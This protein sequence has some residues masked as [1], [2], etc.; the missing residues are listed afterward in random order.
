MWSDVAKVGESVNTVLAKPE[1]AGKVLKLPAGIFEV[2]N[3]RDQNAG[4]RVP[5]TVKGI[6]GAGRD[7]II[8]M[9]ANTSSFGKTVPTQSAGSTN[10]LYLLRMNDGQGQTLSDFWLQGTEQ[11]HLYNGIMVGNSSPGTTVENL[12][13]TGIPGDAGTPPGETFG[14]NWWRGSDS[15]TRDV[16]IDGYRWTGDSFSSRV[17]GPIVGA[18]PIGYNNHDEARL[19]NVLTHDSEVGMPTFWYSDN[20]QTWNLQ[21][22]RNVTGINHEESFNIVHH[23]PVIHG[24]YS[25]RHINFMSNKSDGKLTIIGATTDE[26][27]SGSRSGPIGKGKRML[28]LTPY[29]YRSFNDN[30][31]KSPPR[32][33]LDDGVTA[34]PYTWAH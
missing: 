2:S 13:I 21:S 19:I 26:W 20:A 34:V 7:T 29:S 27:I 15:V 6:V 11:G 23:Q 24:S 1:L 4:I 16:E 3:F 10:Q 30:T 25:R 33:V 17:R 9:K 28:V 18:S 12:L 22:I 31:I 32:V 14:L 8:R 5:P